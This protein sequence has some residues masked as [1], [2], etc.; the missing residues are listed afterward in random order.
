M[1]ANGGEPG[2]SLA[3]PAPAAVALAVHCRR[4]RRGAGG[5][6]WSSVGSWAMP[7][8]LMIVVGGFV[9]LALRR[10]VCL[11]SH[12]RQTANQF[13]CLCRRL[14]DQPAP[15]LLV[16]CPLHESACEHALVDVAFG[17]DHN[18]D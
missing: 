9:V 8:G 13:K 18:S 14:C 11:R 17:S 12:T 4:R 6:C 10:R 2:C 15:L 16:R 5:R 7:L 3:A 1:G